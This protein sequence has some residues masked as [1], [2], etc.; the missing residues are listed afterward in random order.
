MYDELDF[1]EI[2]NIREIKGKRR[3]GYDKAQFW[4]NLRNCLYKYNI[5]HNH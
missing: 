1:M 5:K 2:Q 4:P 3:S